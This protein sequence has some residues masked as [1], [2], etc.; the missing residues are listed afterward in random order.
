M[1]REIFHAVQDEEP[2]KN[3]SDHLLEEYY[4]R[5]RDRE[6]GVIDALLWGVKVAVIIGGSWFIVEMLRQLSR[7][8][9]GA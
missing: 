9:A 7:C 2:A 4:A 6:P 8:F 1:S 3:R 5:K